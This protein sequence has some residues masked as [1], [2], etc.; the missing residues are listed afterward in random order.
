LRDDAPLANV[1]STSLRG[2][3]RRNRIERDFPGPHTPFE[4]MREDGFI[5]CGDR[6]YVTRW[7]EMLSLFA[8][9]EL[10]RR[11]GAWWARQSVG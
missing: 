9:Q 6:D 1:I 7:L 10:F 11:A 5:V 2:N 4:Q 8:C 3:S